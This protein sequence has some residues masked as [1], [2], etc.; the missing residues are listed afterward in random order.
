MP[1]IVLLRSILQKKTNKEWKVLVVDYHSMRILSSSL[2][3]YDILEE[4]LCLVDNIEADEER[5][6]L[7]QLGALYL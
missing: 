4:G 5:E 2:S 3:M 1:Y 6:Q 7:P